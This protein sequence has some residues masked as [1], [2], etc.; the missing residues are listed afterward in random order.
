MRDL[1]WN[2]KKQRK[3][4]LTAAWLMIAGVV[5]AA[6][7]ERLLMNFNWQFAY[8]HASDI[9]Q[10]FNV[11]TRYFTYLAKAGYGDGAAAEGFDD[12]TWRTLDLPHDWAVEQASPGM[13]V[14]VMVIKRWDMLFPNPV[15]AGTAR[16]LRCRLRMRES[17]FL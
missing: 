12:R 2:K 17:V 3:L 5:L 4:F 9:E 14:T 16:L 7:R 6:P 15:W 11:G 8:G 13:P 10:D 1:I